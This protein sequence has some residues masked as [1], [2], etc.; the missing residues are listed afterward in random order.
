MATG[1]QCEFRFVGELNGFLAPSRR[2]ATVLHRFDG[3][4]S[5][6]DQVEALGV[7]HTEIAA[8]LVDG[9]PVGFGYLLRGGEQIVVHPFGPG[10]PAGSSGLL[11]PERAAEA[12]FIADVH[13]GRLA[14]YL[15]LLGFDCGWRNDFG[16]DELVNVANAEDRIVLTRDTGLLKRAALVHGAFVH[17]SD[18][19]RQLRE[20][21]DRF[22]L[23]SH[24][25]PFTRCARCNGP[26]SPWQ[27]DRDDRLPEA[28]LRHRD[29]LSRCEGCGQLY[30]PGSHLERLRRRLAEVGVAV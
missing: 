2:H 23:E 24:A 20:V 11:R 17:A 10:L 18:P 15:R 4:P 30:W 7:P 29:G 26:V 21:F 13:L 22:G 12:R 8:L 19:R 3:T 6:K 27:P 1:R 25:R 14:S 5:V 28:A 16:D 9:H